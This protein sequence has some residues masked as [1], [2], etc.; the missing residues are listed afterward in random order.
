LLSKA[1]TQKKQTDILNVARELFLERGYDAVSLDDILKRVG[2]SKTTLYSYYGGKEGLF[3]AMIRKLCHDNLGALLTMDTADLDP[4]A[5]LNAI[6]RQFVAIISSQEGRAVFRAM[7]AEAQRFPDLAK[8]FFEAGPESAIRV[9]RRSIEHWQK[10]GVLRRAD[11]EMLAIQFLGLMMGNFHVK[12][13]LGIMEPLTE[14]QIK[15]WVERGT[16]TFLEG[17]LPRRS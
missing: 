5:G 15:A 17:L 6:G 8:A 1:S 14:K 16:E 12:S 9:L 7:I 11:P 3:A 10:K 13:L 4:K 2:G